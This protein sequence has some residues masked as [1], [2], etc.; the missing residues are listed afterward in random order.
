M[1]PVNP[2]TEPT[3]RSILADTMTISIPTAR[4]AVTDICVIRLE[5]FRGVRK[6]LSVAQWKYAQ[7]SPRTT[8]MMYALSVDLVIRDLLISSIF[9]D[10][11]SL[12]PSPF[13]E[14]PVR[15]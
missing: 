4:M 15:G 10:A 13:P 3:D 5:R 7:I 11:L 1:P 6:M 8:I 12:P 9:I 2:R 14:L